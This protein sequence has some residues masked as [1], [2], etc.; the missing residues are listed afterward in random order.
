[1]I[2]DTHTHFNIEKKG[3]LISSEDYEVKS[4]NEN[5]EYRGRKV[6]VKVRNT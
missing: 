3:S 2:E 1:M 4:P 5:N 6:Q